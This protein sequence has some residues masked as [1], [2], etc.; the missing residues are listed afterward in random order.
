MKSLLNRKASVVFG[1]GLWLSSISCYAW[2]GA[3]SGKVTTF[4]VT[5]GGNYAFRVYLDPTVSMCAGGPNWAYLND[6][7]SNY[8]AYVANLMMAKALGGTV[9]IYSMRVGPYCNIGHM[10]V[11]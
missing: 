8:K 7:D 5:N 1:I 4:E 10:I 6:T 2:D 3:A 11:Q 9:T